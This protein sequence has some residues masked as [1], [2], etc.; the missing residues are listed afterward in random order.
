TNRTYDEYIGEAARKV[1]GAKHW[2]RRV[3]KIVGILETIINDDALY[4][5]GGNASFIEVPLPANGKTVSNAAGIA[6]GVHLRDERMDYL[7]E[8]DRPGFVARLDVFLFDVDNTLLDN[9]GIHQALRDHLLQSYGAR[10]C[11]CCWALFEGL[12]GELG[13]ADYLGA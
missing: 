13:Y 1:I 12:R 5:G 9:D 10:A 6:G 8:E 4:V 11:E 3:R 7:F 2:N